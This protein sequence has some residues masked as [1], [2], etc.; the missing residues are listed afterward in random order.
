MAIAFRCVN[1][2]IFL[3]VFLSA[4]LT[5]L[6]N[7]NSLVTYDSLILTATSTSWF[8]CLRYILEALEYL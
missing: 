5:I 7:Q 2:L 6:V 1:T 4:T 3:L 8:D